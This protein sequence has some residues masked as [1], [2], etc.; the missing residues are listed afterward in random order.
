MIPWRK[1]AVKATFA[2]TGMFNCQ[3]NGKGMTSMMAPV[4]T[5]GIDMKRAKA[6]S[7]MHPPP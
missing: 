4:T 5:L 2:A 6:S 7:L 1:V 3:T